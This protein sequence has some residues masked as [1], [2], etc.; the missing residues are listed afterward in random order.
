MILIS[1]FKLFFVLVSNHKTLTY[2]SNYTTK[3]SPNPSNHFTQGSRF[4]MKFLWAFKCVVLLQIR[5]LSPQNFTFTLFWFF[6]SLFLF[7]LFGS[8][9]KSSNH[10]RNL[11]KSKIIQA[12]IFLFFNLFF[13]HFAPSER[14]ISLRIFTQYCEENFSALSTPPKSFQL[15]QKWRS[16]N[17]NDWKPRFVGTQGKI[18]THTCVKFTLRITILWNVLMNF[19]VL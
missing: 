14:D 13:Q 19:Q 5:L 4:F 9:I 6:K 10:S 3:L 11:F 7:T 2:I 18:S 15:S 16:K 1:C 17:E 8:L 12:E